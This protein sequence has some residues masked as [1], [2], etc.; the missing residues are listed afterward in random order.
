MLFRSLTQVRQ[1]CET[2]GFGLAKFVLQKQ[3]GVSKPER[4]GFAKLT[5]VLEKLIDIAK[6]VERLRAAGN[7]IGEE[8]YTALC[9]ELNLAS[10][11]IDD[12]PDRHTLQSLLQR[13]EADGTQV[14]E[15]ATV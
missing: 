5:I 9:R 15:T 8:R 3:A 1:L 11:S 4:I 7:A 13:V 10:A 12:I 6:G 2:V 14:N